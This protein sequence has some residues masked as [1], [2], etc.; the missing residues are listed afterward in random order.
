LDKH[1]DRI[2]WKHAPVRAASGPVNGDSLFRGMVAN[3]V[4]LRFPAELFK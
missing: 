3:A 2:Q 4:D 1:P